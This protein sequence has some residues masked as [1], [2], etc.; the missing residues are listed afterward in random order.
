[1]Q[2]VKAMRPDMGMGFFAIPEGIIM[3][4]GALEGNNFTEHDDQHWLLSGVLG[5]GLAKQ[6][7]P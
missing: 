3:G 7:Y 6:L 5:E 1:M 2:G 4:H